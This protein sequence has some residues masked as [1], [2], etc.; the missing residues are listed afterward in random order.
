MKDFN[1]NKYIRNKTLLREADDKMDYVSDDEFDIWDQGEESDPIGGPLGEVGS[2]AMDGTDPDTYAL[3]GD[4]KGIDTRRME[5]I[6]GDRIQSAVEDLIENSYTPE[7]ILE[8]CKKYI[9]DFASR[10]SYL[11]AQ[12]RKY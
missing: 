8:L 9:D 10:K 1:F 11:K 6:G 5:M 12:G 2:N 7:D 3:E 4:D